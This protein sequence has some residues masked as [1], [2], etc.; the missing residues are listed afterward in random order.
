MNSIS[1]FQTTADVMTQ[2]LI[3][4]RR[5]KVLTCTAMLISAGTAWSAVFYVQTTGNDASSGTSWVLAKRSITNAMLAAAAGD[6]IW[7]SS[8][9]YTQLVTLKYNVPLYGGGHF[10]ETAP[11][12]RPSDT[13]ICRVERGAIRPPPVAH[14]KSW[15]SA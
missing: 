9:I 12:P 4:I 15:G 2:L 6:Q 11:P 3:I 7:V 8:G 1:P 13:Q 10:A 14:H 5:V